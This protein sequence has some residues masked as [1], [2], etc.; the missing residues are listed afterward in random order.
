[1]SGTGKR[2]VL[3]IMPA[4]RRDIYQLTETDFEEVAASERCKA[5]QEWLLGNFPR[6]LA[7]YACNVA[8]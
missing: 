7:T 2:A 3:C 1:M 8:C 6:H 4:L 5:A